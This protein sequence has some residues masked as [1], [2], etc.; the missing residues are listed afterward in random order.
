M[1][2]PLLGTG[3]D[4][5]VGSRFTELYGEQHAITNLS[6]HTGVDITKQ[7]AVEKAITSN[8]AE[9]VIHAAAFTDVKA[10][11]EQKDDTKGLAYQVNVEGTKNVAA[12]CNKTGKHLIHISTDYVFDGQN[13]DPYTE[14]DRPDPIEWYGETKWMA[15]QAV[16]ASGAD[17]TIARIAFPYRAKF[18]TKPDIL[19]KTLSGLKDGSL[20]PQFADTLITP[21]FIDDIA[22]VLEL[23]IKQKPS[24][25]WH[26]TGSSPVSNYEFAR[27][28]AEVFNLDPTQVKSGSLQEYLKANP[29]RPY[30]QRLAISNHKL[31]SKLNYD[32]STLT[33]G[34]SAIKQQLNENT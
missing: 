19:A 14:E 32:M 29:D 28:V 34:L 18:D 27:T 2:T 10:A 13:T 17:F 25:V 1:N 20:Y 16:A 12:A 5:L 30:H 33:E 3:L 24:G 8:P 4:G 26:V 6:L 23:L 22:H 31:A 7:Q 15:E 9:V 21:T 11:F